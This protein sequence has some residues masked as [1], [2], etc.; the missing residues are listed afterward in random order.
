MA[1][2]MSDPSPLEWRRWRFE[3]AEAGTARAG[4]ADAPGPGVD[5]GGAAAIGTT[6]LPPAAA[7]N[8]DWP[9]DEGPSSPALPDRCGVLL[10]C[11]WL[12]GF[13]AASDNEEFFREVAAELEP[14]LPRTPAL[15]PD[16]RFRFLM[17]SV[18]KLRGRTTPWSFRNRP[19][20]LHRGW[21]SGF[22]RHKGVVWV[23][24]F[25]HVVGLPPS[26]EL[27]PAACKF[28]VDPGCEIGGDEGRLGAAD[29]KPDMVPATS[30]CGD[31]GSDCAI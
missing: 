17:T 22:R 13:D 12:A 26:P 25:V 4:I 27:P 14:F 11:C 3:E 5:L 20:A 18:F 23:K 21:P 31:V 8:E 30:P 24:Q 16:P 15:L 1:E 10:D 9:A 2:D 28:V 29:E 7:P 19:H 6:P